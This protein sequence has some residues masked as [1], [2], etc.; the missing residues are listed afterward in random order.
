MTG[1]QYP[2]TGVRDVF[3]PTENVGLPLEETTIAEQLKKQNYSTAIVGKWHLGNRL[4]YLPGNQ[5]FDYYLGIPYSDD[6][7]NGK[8]TQCKASDETS[9]E[10]DRA[11]ANHK[12][13]ADGDYASWY[14]PLVYQKHNRTKIVEQPLDFST[15]GEKYNQFTTKFIEENRD[16]PF[17]L[18]MPFQHVHATS[19]FND[20]WEKMPNFQ[21]TGCDFRKATKRGAYGDALAEVDWMVGNVH[22]ALKTHGLEENTLI[23]FTSDNGPW[24]CLRHQDGGSAGIFSGQFAGYSCTG[25]GSTWEGG[26][27]EPAFSYWKGQIDP[28]SRSS[29][30]ISSMDVFP[31]FSRLAGINISKDAVLD[32]RDMTD[33][34]LRDNGK[35]KHDFLFH[36]GFCN[37]A[38]PRNG[39]TAV[40]HGPYKAHWCTAPGIGANMSDITHYKYPLLFN[41][42]EDPS[43]AYPLCDGKE[44]PG[45]Q[46]YRAAII[47]IMRAYA[48]EV[49]T[50]EYG[51]LVPLPD[52]PGEGPGRYGLCCDRS[53]NCTC[54]TSAWGEIGSA[55]FKIGSMPHHDKYHEIFEEE[56]HMKT[57][58]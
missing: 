37:G 47:R 56:N 7:G 15:L 41:V 54:K 34:L 53:K 1:R 22:K 29:E 28:F 57:K 49:A 3:G 58:Y 52:G 35:S 45:R 27:R 24:G 13:P 31:T 5:G 48:M 21:Y 9:F 2:R 10:Y 33:I 40:R 46:D 4:R 8:F 39:I 32:G 25:K 26:I 16:K 44:L 12:P 14:L 6:M 43:E 30:T 11:E 36:Y 50:F 51:D 19:G 18:Y 20:D 17:F 42:E 23:V 38:W 55:L